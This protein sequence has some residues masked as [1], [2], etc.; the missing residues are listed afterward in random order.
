M[1]DLEQRVSTL[2]R[3]MS[4]LKARVDANEDDARNIPDLIKAEF[5][6]SNSQIARL[7]RD[8]AELQRNVAELQS[9]FGALGGKFEALPRV[10]A[11]LVVE[12]LGDRDRKN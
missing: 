5:R 8:V 10:V 3:E 12:M 9:G 1:A 4:S 11:E 7:S 2:E 6:L